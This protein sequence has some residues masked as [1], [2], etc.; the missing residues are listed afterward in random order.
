M[1]RRHEASR[2]TER[3]TQANRGPGLGIGTGDT[4]AQLEKTIPAEDCE[5]KDIPVLPN[6]EF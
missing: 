5:N 1:L 2:I 4:L 6:F 3:M